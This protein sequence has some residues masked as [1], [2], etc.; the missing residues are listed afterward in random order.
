MYVYVYNFFLQNCHF[1]YYSANIFVMAYIWLILWGKRGKGDISLSHFY[2]I[3]HIKC[4]LVCM[5]WTTSP[6]FKVAKFLNIW[7][8]WLPWKPLYYLG[9]SQPPNIILVIFYFFIDYCC[10]TYRNTKPV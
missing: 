4:N 2:N 5:C 8:M 9:I 10:S 6:V 7:L 3:D 1:T